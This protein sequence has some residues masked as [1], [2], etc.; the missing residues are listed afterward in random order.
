MKR[1][2]LCVL[3]CAASIASCKKAD[4]MPTPVDPG[5]ETPIAPEGFNFTTS[6][7]VHLD[8]TLK[9][10]DD[11]ILSGVMVNV[12]STSNTKSPLYTA[13]SD[14]NGTI[15]ATLMVP[16]YTDTLL[17]DPAYIGLI[18]NALG[19]INN[20]SLSC[21]IGGSQGYSGDV[22][23]NES[24]LGDHLMLSGGIIDNGVEGPV[25]ITTYTYLNTYDHSGRPN[26]LEKS[27]AISPELLSFINASLPEQKP[28]PT[29]HPDFL[30][31]S[32]E[33]NLN[34]E[35]RSDVWIT[36]VH[37]GAG[38]YNSLGFYKYNTSK[39]PASLSDID[40]I[41]IAIP[42]ASLVGSGGNMHSGDKINL[43][44]FEPGTSIGFVVFQNAWNS[45]T[46]LVNTNAPKFFGDDIL[47][48]EK[49]GFE[50]HTVLLYDDKNK[51]FLEG[52]EDLQ[53][54]N[55]SS[56]NDFNDLIYYVSAN[57]VD[58]IS[59][60]K[61]NP[62]D[63][64]V[65]SDGDGVSDTY[66]KFPKDPT[67]AYV[68]YFP[69]Q[70]TWGTLAFEDLWPSVGDYDL[71]DLVVNYQYKVINNAL[72]KT[73]EIDGDYTI[74]GLGATKRNGFAIQ[75]P[76]AADKV[77]SVTGQQ[78]LASYIKTNSNGTEAGQKNA[79]IVPFDDPKALI[80]QLYANTTNGQ[81]NIKSD[82][83]HIQIL[84]SSALTA[85]ELGTAPFNP[86]IILS[87]QR[88]YEV[89]LPGQ[90]P[91]D[92]ADTKLFGSGDDRTSAAKN[93]YYLNGTNWPWALSFVE[94]FEYPAESNNIS[95][96][97]TQ[98]LK[99]AQ[100]GGITNTDWYKNKDYRNS[101]LIYTR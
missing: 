10:N 62:I 38:Y 34:I 32:A 83:A 26:K 40:N 48:T 94:D 71:N 11:K 75:F 25:G 2:V 44:R 50:R 18:R 90:Q 82:T 96:V 89:H 54:D 13:I 29:Y 17:I 5:V 30:T 70:D 84:L 41:T 33:T 3:I 57:P 63:K 68:Q 52:F 64:P 1:K 59:V 99:W 56:D 21:V 60:E 15:S 92:L 88:G 14:I 12:Y 100:S 81:A 65:D 69:S 67:K 74:K 51:L 86:F 91:T 35:K 37:E 9:T 31:E 49:T 22:I 72:N 79:V 16:S 47:N 4:V 61:V 53:R 58:A 20:N 55:G 73:I 76:F 7:P 66:D 19:I 46:R 36:F 87:Q 97:Y 78:F 98:F 43:G 8:V 77:K 6:K 80:A 95:K 101:D 45:G 85:A 23:A 28:V 24:G 39:P 93:K 42:N 27:D